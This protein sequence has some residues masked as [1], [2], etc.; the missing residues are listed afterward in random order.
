MT[1]QSAVLGCGPRAIPHIMAYDGVDNMALVAAC[2]MNA[3][4]LHEHGKRF[5]IPHLYEDLDTMLAAEKPDVLHIV[6]PPGIREQPIELAAR[7]KVKVAVV[8]KPIA[9]NIEQARVI[10][11]IADRTGIKIVVNTQRRYYKA[12]QE[13]RRLQEAGRFGETRFMRFVTRANIMSWGP[14]VVDL[15]LFLLGDAPPSHVWATA[16]G[17]NGYDYG[18]PAPARMLIALT[19]PH[20]VMVYLEAADDAVGVPGVTDFW[21]HAEFDLWGTRGRAW[22]TMSGG[23]GYQGDGDA[24]PCLEDTGLDIDEVPG[25]RAFT[26]AIARWLDDEADRHECRLQNALLGFDVTMAAYHSATLGRRV[27]FPA[28]VPDD[29]AETLE[30]RLTNT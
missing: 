27:A 11:R 3:A 9:L 6:T 5:K 14:H 20:D 28:E 15:I 17:M 30:K 29:I 8:E 13:I 12:F 10:R 24:A 25:Q 7:H 19:F 21:E 2:D 18:H 16:E 22:W 1:Y 26:R 23:W 4:R